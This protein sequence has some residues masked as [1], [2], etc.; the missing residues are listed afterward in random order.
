[1]HA[2]GTF[3]V[4]IVPQEDRPIPMLDR[5]TIDK[6]FSGGLEGSSRGQMLSGGDPQTGSAGYVAMERFEGK[7]DGKSGSFILQHS[8]TMHEGAHEMSVKIVPG[9]GTD[10]L[11]GITGSLA[12]TVEAGRHRYG[13]DYALA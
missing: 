13:L 8:A 10:E 6:T 2:A 4:N 12:I 1:M 5:M 3:E 9:S 11:C 7:L